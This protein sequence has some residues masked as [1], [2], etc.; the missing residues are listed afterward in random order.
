MNKI[1]TIAFFL[2]LSHTISAQEETGNSQQI[3]WLSFT[4]AVEANKTEPKKFLI[5]V[6]TSWCGWCK[7]MDNTTFKDPEVVAY[8]KEH[9]HAV[10]LNAERKDTVYLNE[11]IFVNEKP[12]GRRHPHQLAISLMQGKMSY[13]TIVYLDESGNMLQPIPGFQS[14]ENILPILYFFGENAY[15]NGSWEDFQKEFTKRAN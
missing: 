14:K 4:E 2:V 6:Y 5:D 8:V 10:K 12:N 3:E 13:P 7:K 9:Y 15:R 1:L 11:Q